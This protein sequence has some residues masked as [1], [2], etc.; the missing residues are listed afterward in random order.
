M[1]DIAERLREAGSKARNLAEEIARGDYGT[2]KRTDVSS[3]VMSTN[4]GILLIIQFQDGVPQ[5]PALPKN[6]AGYQVS[7]EPE[8][9][10]DA[11]VVNC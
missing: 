2:P 10:T 5:S 9:V 7:Y 1:A 11:L 6:Y 8:R 4:K 3:G